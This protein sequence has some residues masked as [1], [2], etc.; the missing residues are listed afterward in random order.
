MFSSADTASLQQFL[1]VSLFF[2]ALLYFLKSI[3][4]R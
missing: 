1:I 4:Y 3:T 2:M